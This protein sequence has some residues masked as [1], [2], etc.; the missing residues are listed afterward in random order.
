M[1]TL[2][3]GLPNAGKTTYSSKYNTVIHFDDCPRKGDQYANC[4]RRASRVKGDVCVEG[5]YNSARRRKELLQACAHQDRKVCIW[6]DTDVDECVRREKEYRKRP[7]CLVLSHNKT[8]EPPTLE[9]G[10]DEVVVIK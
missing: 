3:C 7:I 8:L 9:E 2:I 5:V 6:L 10:W 1:L 4:N